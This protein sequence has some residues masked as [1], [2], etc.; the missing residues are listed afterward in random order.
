MLHVI[1][2][3]GLGEIGL[4][5]MV[6]A[7][8][9]ELLLIDC[10][11]M[12]PPSDM[13]G[14]DVV[15]PDFTYLRQNAAALK[16][17]VL[18]HGHEDHV[19]ALPYLLSEMAHP[20][21]LYGTRFTLALVRHRLEEAGVPVDLRVIEPR[22]P[23]PVGSVFTVEASRVAHTIPDAV[24]YIVRTP[25]GTVIH[26][27]DFKLDPDPI[28][29]LRTDL[30][31]WGEVGDEGVLCL[32]SD[33]T[34]SELVGE[35]GSERVVEATLRQRLRGVS[36]RIVVA[37]FASNVHRIRHLLELF[38]EQ[39]RKVALLGRSMARNVAMARE[40]GYLRAP[41]SLF[42]TPE[43]AA[44][45]PPAKVAV[46]TTGSQAEPR[47][48][49]V[50]LSQGSGP[51][52][53]GPEDLVVVSSRPIPG[54]ER[55]VGALL[56]QLFWRGAKVVYAQLEPGVHVSGHASRPQQQRVLETVRPRHFVPVHGELRHLH[57]HVATARE[58][59][60]TAR[61]ASAASCRR[62]ASSASASARAASP[63]RRSPSA[64]AWPRRGC[65]WRWRCCSGPTTSSRPCS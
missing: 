41:A 4:N 16:G 52:R 37:L 44:A 32:L 34:N 19:G 45:L 31:R 51:L 54:N 56:D 13:P 60:M 59:G 36:E 48:G 7:C 22:E 30:E 21:P 20:P 58:L 57:R 63:R 61:A 26:T 33:S 12:F 1:P 42:V 5:A 2:L 15:V 23:F 64:P 29:G 18:T 25:E 50:Q 43:E 55:A 47:S 6:L 38:E 3:G 9:G 14:V 53:L 65:W 11:V 17:I 28:D 49:L 10:G 46:L 40:L 35:T 27:G 62:G 39:G 24:G 8:R